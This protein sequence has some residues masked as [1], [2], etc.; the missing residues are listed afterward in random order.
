MNGILPL[1]KPAGMTSHDCVI[2]VRKIFETKKVGHTGTLDP[3]VEGVL[4]ICIG[5][6]TKAVPF[7]TSLKKTYIAECS[8][9]TSTETEDAHGKIIEEKPVI[10]PPAKQEIEAVLDQFRGEITQIPPMYS[11]VKVNGKKLYEY[12]R[13]NE[14]VERPVRQVYIHKLNMLSREDGNR[15]FRMEVKC[16]EGTYIRTL[17]VDIGRKLGYPAHMSA[18]KRIEASSFKQ[19]DTVSFEEIH[20]AKKKNEEQNLLVPIAD[21]L[22]HFDR[23]YVNEEI[24][25]K[26]RNGQKLPIPDQSLK[27]DP[28]LIMHDNEL[29]AI[30]Q[31][32]PDNTEEIKPV[33]VF[34]C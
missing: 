15:K 27:S 19:E 14:H 11:A 9:G 33:R 28:F 4:G 32:H 31:I 34:S 1:W 23:L 18:L 22:K 30:Y 3:E 10:N 5:Q 29:L 26:V 20:V 2:K 24:K 21:T 6:A 12:A 8:L 25:R 17:C 7:L 16:S 13:A